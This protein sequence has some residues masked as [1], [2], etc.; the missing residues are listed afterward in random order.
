MERLLERQKF[1]DLI[2][3]FAVMWI[4][5]AK[6]LGAYYPYYCG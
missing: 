1:G 2:V 3:S 5:Y 6:Q 4:G